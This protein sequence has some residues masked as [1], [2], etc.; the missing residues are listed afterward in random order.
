M[1]EWGKET[2]KQQRMTKK[3]KIIIMYLY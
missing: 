2:K 3:F 1:G